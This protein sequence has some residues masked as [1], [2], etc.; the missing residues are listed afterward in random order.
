VAV[1]PS[2]KPRAAFFCLRSAEH[3]D[4]MAVHAAAVVERRAARSGRHSTM[5]RMRGEG[6]IRR[7]LDGMAVLLHDRRRRPATVHTENDGV[8]LLTAGYDGRK[9]RDH[10]A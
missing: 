5:H 9:K 1:I 2:K 10:R 7:V 8:I 3:S 4:L 6:A